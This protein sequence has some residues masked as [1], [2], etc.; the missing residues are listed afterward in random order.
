[1]YAFQ[2]KKSVLKSCASPPL[3]GNTPTAFRLLLSTN[4]IL[5]Y[6]S[7][8]VNIFHN[9]AFATSEMHIVWRF[10]APSPGGHKPRPYGVF[11]ILFLMNDIAI[12][13]AIKAKPSETPPS[14]LHTGT[15]MRRL[16]LPDTN[17]RTGLPPHRTGAFREYRSRLLSFYAMPKCRG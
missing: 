2:Y 16:T 7:Y 4:N 14:A 1:M 13:S 15:A 5:S 6:S 9:S 3:G 12:Q 10:S 8:F 11:I 17:P